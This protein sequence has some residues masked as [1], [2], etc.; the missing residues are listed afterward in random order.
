YIA[1]WETWVAG[2]TLSGWFIIAAI[3][4]TIPIIITITH[5]RKLDLMR[6]FAATKT[7]ADVEKEYEE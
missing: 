5:F 1:S 4:I 2:N 6:K 7:A 3:S